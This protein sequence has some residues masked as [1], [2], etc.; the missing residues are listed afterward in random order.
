MNGAH[1][2]LSSSFERRR[3][4]SIGNVVAPDGMAPDGMA[5]DRMR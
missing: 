4:D 3:I 2:F 1:R 5:P